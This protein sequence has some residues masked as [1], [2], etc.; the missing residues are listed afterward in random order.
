MPVVS[1]P[2]AIDRPRSGQGGGVHPPAYGGGGDNGP[3]DGSPDY[4]RR[5]NR[6]R[7]GLLFALAPISMLF[8]TFTV[9]YLFRHVALVFDSRTHT[10]VREWEIGRASCRERV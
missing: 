4:S 1:P 3:G 10:Y 7:L 9:V 6:A 5:L 2:I 8:V